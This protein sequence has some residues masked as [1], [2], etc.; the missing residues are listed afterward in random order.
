MYN[1]VFISIFSKLWIYIV[2]SYKNS[3]L[4]H[5]LIR[6]GNILNKPFKNSIFIKTI[7]LENNFL[8][9]TTIY[10]IYTYFIDRVNNFTRKINRKIRKILNNST[11]IKLTQNQLKEDNFFSLI[12]KFFIFLSVGMIIVVSIFERGKYMLI[13]YLI[14]NLFLLI[15]VF[16]TKDN[17]D[18]FVK[19]SQFIRL[20]TLIFF[21]ENDIS[22]KGGLT[23]D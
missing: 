13:L 16:F 1:S 5:M 21:L 11:F 18:N 6:I 7:F 20:I 9:K 3:F 4:N 8:E 14:L 2:N 17:I 15:M 23:N 12:L 10:S 19:N 22:L